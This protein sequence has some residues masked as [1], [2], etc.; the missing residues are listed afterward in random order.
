MKKHFI[1]LAIAMFVTVGSIF[2]NGTEEVNQRVVSAFNKEF[3]MAK[4]VE[5]QLSK[6]LFKATFKMNDQ[7]LFAFFTKEGE[8]L[9]VS[10]NLSSDQLPIQ[11]ATGLKNNYEGFWISDLFELSSQNETGYY[12]TIE[13]ADQKIVLK[14]Y[15]INGW[16]VYKKEKKE[17]I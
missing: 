16:Q 15:G 8:M 11:L 7:V 17:L 10:R 13:N 9:A 3:K 14:S 6:D 5:W 1:T 12:V 4:D 2:A